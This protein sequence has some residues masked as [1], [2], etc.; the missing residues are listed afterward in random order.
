M[1][2]VRKVFSLGFSSGSDHERWA[3][4]LLAASNG[5]QLLWIHARHAHVHGCR[6]AGEQ[7]EHPVSLLLRARARLERQEAAAVQQ[8]VMEMGK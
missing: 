7:L 2:R 4:A 1:K 6:P 3:F 8:V 5:K